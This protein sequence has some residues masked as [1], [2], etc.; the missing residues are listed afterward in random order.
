VGP[1]HLICTDC[2]RRYNPG[3]IDYVCPDCDA[4]RAPGEPLRGVLRIEYEPPYADLLPIPALELLPPL[5]LGPTPLLEAPRL[6]DQLGLPS[7]HLKDDTRLPTGSLKDRASAMVVAKARELGRRVVTTAS[8]GNAATALA[9][10]CAAC[11]L[12]SVIFVPADA[13][14]A[15]LAQMLAYGAHMLPIAGSYDD[16]FSLCLAAGHEFAWYNRSTAYN[17]YTIEGKKTVA[18]EIWEQLGRCVPDAV[19]VPTGDGA[20][21]AGMYKG[22]HD[23]MTA[24]RSS[25]LPRLFAVQAAGSAAIV[26]AWRRG[27]TRVTPLAHVETVADSIRVASPAN[28]SWALR[29]LRETN[30]AGVIVSDDEIFAAM[31]LLAT[32]AGVFAEPAAAAALAGLVRA[33]ADGLVQRTDTIVLLVTGSGLKDLD[34][35]L[36]IA[37]VPAPVAPSLAAVRAWQR[38][39]FA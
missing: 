13:P 16:A 24:R 27:D 34:A 39:T 18:F 15:K 37:R 2:G 11:G 21:L 33:R 25:A 17:P 1:Y 22:F 12:E 4:A 6:R 3:Q 31:A 14:R 30:G 9:A 19:F 26:S 36:R 28:G 23:L 5:P 29:V 7:L 8:T 20:V 38:T 10:M 32:T 35:A